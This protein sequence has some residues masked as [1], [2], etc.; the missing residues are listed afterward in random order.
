MD[1]ESVYINYFEN[2]AVKL[3]ELQH[4]PEKPCFF[5]LPNRYD[6][7]EMDEA[8]RSSAKETVMLLDAYESDLSEASGDNNIEVINAAFYIIERSDSRDLT[9]IKATRSRCAIIGNKVIAKLRKD[10][11]AK[12]SGNASAFP[13]KEFKFKV[14][15]TSVGPM[16]DQYYG[17]LFQF[18]LLSSVDV[19]FKED[20]W[21]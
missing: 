9:S 2:A 20:D 21:L 13:F 5:H 18:E 1:N 6:L 8:I 14:N 12:R 15:V 10:S 4:S 7:A 3:K 19:V 17:K 16:G 11:R